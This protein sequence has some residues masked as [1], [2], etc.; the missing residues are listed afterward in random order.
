MNPIS[1]IKLNVKIMKGAMELKKLNNEAIEKALEQN[2]FACIC[3]KAQKFQIAEKHLREALQALQT[4]LN[5][6]Q[7][8]GL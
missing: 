1:H 6:T 8:S 3:L 2:K 4:Q 7:S 5:C